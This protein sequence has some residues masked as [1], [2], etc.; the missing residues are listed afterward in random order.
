VVPNHP[1]EEIVKK[2][3]LFYLVSVV[4][5]L[6]M[7][8]AACQPAA[9]ATTAPAPAAAEPTA[10]TAAV[11]EPTATTA[12]AEPTEAPAAAEPTAP[13]ASGDFTGLK[14]S[15]PDC[16]YGGEFKSI[17]AVDQMTVKFSLCAPD[18]AFL[19]KLS[20]DVFGIA[21]KAEL[22]K[23]GGDSVK[24]SDEAVGTG[25]F[26]LKSWTR[27]DNVTFEANPDYW[28]GKP[29]YDTLILR[30]SEQSAQRLLELQSGQ[31]DGIDNLAPEDFETVTNDSNLKLFPRDPLNIFYIGFNNKIAPFDNEKV[32]QAFAMA[33]DRQRIVDEYYPAG[34]TV[35]E[36]F[37]PPPLV[38]GF[39]KDIPWY[40]YNQEE[41]KKLLAEAGWVE[42]TEV[43][44]SYRNVV[45]V[46]LPSP[47]KVAQEI[48]A[49]LAEVGVKVKI[50]QQESDTFLQNTSDG[51]EGFYML[52]WG[53]DYPDATNFYDYHFANVNGH[54]FGDEYAD[55]AEP[56]RAAGKIADAAERQKLYD[57]VNTAIKQHVPMIPVAHGTSAIAFGASVENAMTSALGNE[58]FYI[59]NP[60]KD[61]LVFVQNGEPAALWCSDETDGE[62][63]RACQ[64][65]YEPLM[66]FKAGTVESEPALAEKYAVNADA[67]EYT[68]TLRQG[69]KFSDGSLLD[70]NDV[71]ASFV[72]QWDAKDPNHKG[73]TGTFEYFGAFFGKN[74]NAPAE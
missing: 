72:S 63:L 19:S 17:E 60:G 9:P 56:I 3:T 55:I 34:S 25:P 14:T 21:K 74:L 32:R 73:R 40:T 33:I 37:A 38:P 31:A 4:V 57:E 35:A 70:A 53:A 69:V 64:Q 48:Q 46:Y 29:A 13:A 6:S 1:K 62:S 30:W 16:N 52:G 24:L 41:A 10:T 15:A 44:F 42:G 71:V 36:N 67:T 28:G 11:A 50:E 43:K 47:D 68:F 39:S 18:P 49:Q 45:R 59:M 7:V 22:D 54:L 8:L 61:T 12:A 58:P 5:V 2:S 66:R 51:K 26:K 23:Q 20:F 27:G 65:I